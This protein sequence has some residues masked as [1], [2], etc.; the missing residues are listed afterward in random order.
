MDNDILKQ[1]SSARQLLDTLQSQAQKENELDRKAKEASVKLETL[2]K[3]QTILLQEA[4]VRAAA[5]EAKAVEA[6]KD[7]RTAKRSA[8]LSNTI[9]LLAFGFSIFQFFFPKLV[10]G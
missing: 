10:S 9:A 3:E 4:N 2:L 6:E 8:A 1:V 5:M 7:A